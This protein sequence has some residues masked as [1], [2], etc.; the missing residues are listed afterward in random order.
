MNNHPVK[1]CRL[2]TIE[3]KQLEAYKNILFE[4][5]EYYRKLYSIEAYQNTKYLSLISEAYLK[6]FSL[7]MMYNNAENKLKQK[8]YTCQYTFN[9]TDCFLLLSSIL[10]TNNLEFNATVKEVIL[11]HCVTVLKHYDLIDRN[12]TFKPVIPNLEITGY[13]NPSTTINDFLNDY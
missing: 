4:A 12:A 8:F 1:N 6:Y 10:P 13:I 11:E 3:K 9:P 5:K 7:D 2:L